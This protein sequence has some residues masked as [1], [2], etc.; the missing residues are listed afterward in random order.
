MSVKTD[1]FKRNLGSSIFIATLVACASTLPHDSPTTATTRAEMWVQFPLIGN[2]VPVQK[3]LH[4][5]SAGQI[6]LVK[7]NGERVDS[8]KIRLKLLERTSI[9]ASDSKK[10]KIISNWAQAEIESLSLQPGHYVIAIESSLTTVTNVMLKF[11]PADPEENSGINR[12]ITGATVLNA[13]A[14]VTGTVNYRNANR[15]DWYQWEVPRKGIV[16]LSCETI[17]QQSQTEMKYIDETGTS[18][19]CLL[20]TLLTYEKPSKLYVGFSAVE[21]SSF[22]DYRVQVSFMPMPE[23]PMGGIILRTTPESIT[24]DLGTDDGI[25]LGTKG[26]IVRGPN[27][28][29][30][31]E[32]ESVLKRTSKAKVTGRINET[33]LNKPVTFIDTVNSN[34]IL[35]NSIVDSK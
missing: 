3:S 12:D 1:C 18:K 33:D 11:T 20:K 17:N 15:T 10:D 28:F 16:T 9:S 6:E 21:I 13:S 24:V 19:K 23:S 2:K 29:A 7:Q 25:Q 8:G 5:K 35:K 31:I 32:I 34:L 30:E 4:V 26:V 22:L 27:D 14:P